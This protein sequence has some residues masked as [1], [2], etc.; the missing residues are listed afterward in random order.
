[1]TEIR[2][3]YMKKYE[4]EHHIELLKY[5]KE[6][7]RINKEKIKALK[8]KQYLKNREKVLLRVK[9][10]QIINSQRIKEYQK[11]YHRTHL[12]ETE[13]YKKNRRSNDINYR[14]RYNLSNRINDVLRGNPKLETT[15]K[16][17]GC[18]IAQLREYLECKFTLGMNWKNYG[19]YGWHVDHIKPCCS[20]DLSK[21]S[22]QRKCFH[23]KNLQPLWAV[24]NRRKSGKI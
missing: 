11:K 24:D 8:R 1:M 12:K 19:F 9:K 13:I 3:L 7:R 14:I 5:R 23:Y 6:Y 21:K 2:K 10:Y 20:F 15:M 4:L 17:V 18:S 16:L 22:E